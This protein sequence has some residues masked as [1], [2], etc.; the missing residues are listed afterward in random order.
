MS[1]HNQ[2]LI[3]NQE[4]QT[5]KE[6]KENDILLMAEKLFKWPQIYQEKPQSP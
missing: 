2:M 4:E 6:S 3:I 5:L 1:S